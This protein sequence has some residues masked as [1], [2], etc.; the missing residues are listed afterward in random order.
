MYG[1]KNW[2][3]TEKQLQT[4]EVF[5][6]KRLRWLAGIKWFDKI[7]NSDLME[8]VKLKKRDTCIV[9]RRWQWLGHILRMQQ[10]RW[11]RR[12]LEWKEDEQKGRED[13]LAHLRRVGYDWLPMKAG[14]NCRAVGGA[15]RKSRNL[16]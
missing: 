3:L 7:S 12:I 4:I 13:L 8:K 1:A 11:P 15:N 9:R 2:A 5:D 16:I 10:Q 14:R 6:R